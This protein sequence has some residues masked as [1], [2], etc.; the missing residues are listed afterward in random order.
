MPDPA[1]YHTAFCPQNRVFKWRHARLAEPYPGRLESLTGPSWREAVRRYVAVPDSN[2][3]LECHPGC[4]AGPRGNRS[5]QMVDR[6]ICCRW[7]ISGEIRGVF[8]HCQRR[9]P[10]IDLPFEPFSA[11]RGGNPD[12]RPWGSCCRGMRAA[13]RQSPQGCSDCLSLLRQMCH[14]DLFLAWRVREATA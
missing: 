8:E 6:Q 1:Y 13:A 3:S 7:I 14:E 5:D 4:H 11:A 12:C 2:M 10:T 9:Y